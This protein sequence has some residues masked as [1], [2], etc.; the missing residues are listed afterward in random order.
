MNDSTIFPLFSI[1]LSRT[2]FL[3]LACTSKL[4]LQI[5]RKLSE[6]NHFNFLRTQILIKRDL[7]HYSC[8]DWKKVFL[9]L[10]DCP[11]VPWQHVFTR[12]VLNCFTSTLILIR[13]LGMD[14]TVKPATGPWPFIEACTCS[15]PEVMKLLLSYPDIDPGQRNGLGLSLACRSGRLGTVQLLLSDSRV[16]PMANDG[17]ALMTACACSRLDIIKLLLSDSRVDPRKC[18]DTRNTYSPYPPLLEAACRYGRTEVVRL[19][20]PG[21]EWSKNVLSRSLTLAVENGHTAIVSLLSSDKR[22]NLED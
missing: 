14:P 16:D 6:C 4:T 18:I 15:D 5:T 20:L 17:I 10:S 12:T 19:L 8:S 22:T 1:L 11:L 13:E 2:S 9:A 7:G 21:R 3:A